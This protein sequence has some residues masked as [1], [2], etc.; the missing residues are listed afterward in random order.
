MSTTD[1]ICLPDI[2]KHFAVM[3]NSN[4]AVRLLLTD[5]EPLLLL[6]EIDSGDKHHLQI[7]RSRIEDVGTGDIDSANKIIIRGDR[8]TLGKVFEGGLHPAQAHAN[9]T[10]EIVANASDQSKLDALGMVLWGV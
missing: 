9:G 8:M 2:L 6:E 3:L 10:L 7:K 1:Q 4:E 5:W